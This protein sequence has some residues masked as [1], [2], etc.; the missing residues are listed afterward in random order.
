MFWSYPMHLGSA[1]YKSVQYRTHQGKLFSFLSPILFFCCYLWRFSTHAY[2]SF[3]LKMHQATNAVNHVYQEKIYKCLK[4]ELM[5]LKTSLHVGNSTT[6]DVISSLSCSPGND[7]QCIPR[8]SLLW[9][10]SLTILSHIDRL[11]TYTPNNLQLTFSIL[12]VAD[13]H[14]LTTYGDIL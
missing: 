10:N 9:C 1:Q 3:Y 14:P 12:V 7:L 6:I 11:K 2:V 13:V 8:W 4:E 5:K